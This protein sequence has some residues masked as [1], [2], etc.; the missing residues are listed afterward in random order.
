VGVIDTLSTAF[1]R[2]GQRLWLIIIPVLLD[3]FFWFGPRL[4]V[5]SVVDDLVSVLERNMAAAPTSAGLPDS[6]A[7]AQALQETVGSVNLFSFLAWGGLGMPS[8][9]SA[10]PIGWWP[11]DVIEVAGIAQW[12]LLQ[13]LLLAVGLLVASLFLGMLAQDVRDDS[14]DLTRLLRRA[15]TH[16]LAMALVIVPIGM[17]ALFALSLGMALR[18]L[19]VFVLAIM[20]WVLIYM[21]FFPQAITLGEAGPLGALLTSFA[22]V[23]ATF[24]S[25]L[26]LVVLINVINRGLAFLWSQLLV[27][28]TTAGT[29]VAVLGN[30]YI[31][32]A[33]TLALFIFYR[34]RLI[35]WHEAMQDQRSNEAHD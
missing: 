1:R 35:L 13:V 5:A 12:A 33:L 7:M 19:L 22:I 31:G 30:A 10:Q 34:D 16:W 18:P 14:L 2:V 24:W 27:S 23:R 26:W 15:P 32:T 25:T 21:T 17:V 9:L 8:I 29:L 6:M 20:V 11:A 4:S 28:P 3:L